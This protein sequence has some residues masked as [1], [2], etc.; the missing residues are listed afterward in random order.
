MT[1]LDIIKASLRINGTLAAGDEPEADEAQDCLDAYNRMV[2]SMFGT[3][4]GPR[5]SPASANINLTALSG[6]TYIVGAQAVIIT[7]PLNPRPGARVGVADGNLGLASHNC[8]VAR[9]GRLL[10]GAASNLT[11]NTNGDARVW[12]Y[13]PDTADWTREQDLELADEPYFQADLV[14]R[15][16]WMLAFML[17]SEFGAE[18]RP[19]V[20]QMATEGRQHFNRVFGRNGR[21]RA[22]APFGAP[23][24]PN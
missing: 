5:V 11:L 23:V 8:T 9:N 20:A 17:M 24:A 6:R 2:R 12:F 4:I 3:V 7:L 19:D 15:L 14:A 16:P 1:V 18:I 22:D 13:R 21:S 10:Q